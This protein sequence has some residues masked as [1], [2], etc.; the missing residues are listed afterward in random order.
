MPTFRADVPQPGSI[1]ADVQKPDGSTLVCDPG[2]IVELTYDPGHPM[3]VRVEEEM[4][5]PAPW[6][7]PVP[8]V[9]P[10]TPEAEGEQ[11]VA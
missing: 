7:P 8:D 6:V 11:P 3:L 2:D 1:L 5:P 4:P 9:E 10:P